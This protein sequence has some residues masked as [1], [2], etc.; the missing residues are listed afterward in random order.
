MLNTAS[1]PP[2]NITKEMCKIPN[3]QGVWDWLRQE[4]IMLIG[5]PTSVPPKFSKSHVSERQYFHGT[6]ICVKNP[7]SS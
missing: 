3:V 1:L 6:Y 5:E 4:K 2:S 7:L